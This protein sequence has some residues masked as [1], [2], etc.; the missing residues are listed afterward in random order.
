M[1]LSEQYAAEFAQ[2]GENRCKKCGRR[3]HGKF[4]SFCINKELLWLGVS[5]KTLRLA[6]SVFR[7]PKTPERFEQAIAAIDKELSK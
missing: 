4:C 6:S 1:K 3:S 5:S 2:G 7:N